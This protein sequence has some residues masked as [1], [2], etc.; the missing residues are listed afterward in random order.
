MRNSEICDPFF[1]FLLPLY[2]PPAKVP[3]LAFLSVLFSSRGIPEEIKKG[4]RNKRDIDPGLT[5]KIGHFEMNL[6]QGKE[7]IVVSC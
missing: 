4:Y 5:I 2:V 1:L 6:L 3:V 7:K